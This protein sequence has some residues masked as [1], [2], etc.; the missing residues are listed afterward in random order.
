MTDVQKTVV[1]VVCS[2][3]LAACIAAALTSCATTSYAAK[4]EQCRMNS[5]TCEE[6]VKCR[7]DLETSLGHT[8]AA[9]CADGGAP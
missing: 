8:W 1:T 9:H 6:Y 3:G 4:T 5:R 2:I 7:G